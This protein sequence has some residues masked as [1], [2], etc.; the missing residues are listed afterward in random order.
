MKKLHII[1]LIAFFAVIAIV[2]M[3]YGNQFPDIVRN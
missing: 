1:I 3:H 2:A